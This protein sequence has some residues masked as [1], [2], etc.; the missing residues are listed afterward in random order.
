LKDIAISEDLPLEELERLN[1]ELKTGITPRQ[2]EGYDLKVPVGR[3]EQAQLAFA[4]APTAPLPGPRRHTVRKGET[5]A[6]VARKYRVSVARLADAN[7]LQAGAKVSRGEILVIPERSTAAVAAK[8][9]AKKTEAA[10]GSKVASASPKRSKSAPAPAAARSYRV[11]G[12]DTLYS[13][14]RRTGTTV[15][16][17]MGANDLQSPAIKPGDRLVIPPKAR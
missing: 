10:A 6:S 5:L 15:D 8:S 13:I 9:P 12:G 3:M 2:P 17:L 14:A 4:S 7:G 1:P 11:R 16:S